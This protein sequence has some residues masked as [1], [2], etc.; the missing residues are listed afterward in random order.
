MS[1]ESPLE[2]IRGDAPWLLDP[3]LG[4]CVV[5][6]SALAEACRR[7]GLAAPDVQDLDLAWSCDLERGEALLQE[8]GVFQQTTDANRARGTTAFRLGGER[9][10]ITSFRGELTDGPMAA[11]IESDLHR[12]DMTVGAIAWWL[13]EDRIVD[14]LG[15]CDDW[16]AKRVV[17]VG[18]PSER[19][20][21]H[22]IRWL[23]Y[24]RKAAGW[25]F[26]LDREIRKIDAE[27]DVLDA[28]PAEAIAAEIRAA[29]TSSP[30][31]G[32]W[33]HELFEIGVLQRVAPEIATQFDGRPAGPIRYHPEVGQSLHMILVLEW[34]FEHTRDLDPADAYAVRFA[35]LCHDL[36]KGLTDPSEFPS[37]RGHEGAGVDVI[38]ELCR[39]LPGL[40]DSTTRLLAAKVS[41]LHLTARQLRELRPG[42]LARMYEEHFR[43][44][45]MRRDLF[46]LAVAADSAGRLGMS[47]DGLE[48]AARVEAD[49]DWL[50][51]RCES[52]DAGELRQRHSDVEEF[53][54]ALHEARARELRSS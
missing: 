42:T 27:F 51:E 1:I 37:H 49:L 25:R 9:I 40:A 7:R 53:K 30:S 38:G 39:R 22:P 44:K 15:G 18:D 12:R 3:E 10:E 36:G 16:T 34:A 52:V 2:R 20:R 23:R 24:Y 33:L 47:D 48:I 35:A 21:E 32:R 17:A 41:A 29:L 46:A 50:C 26:E 13:A 6:S 19:V 45:A 43:G 11:R 5:G 54:R 4:T 8:H 14:P 28:I 31:P